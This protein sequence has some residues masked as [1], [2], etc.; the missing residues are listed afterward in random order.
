MLACKNLLISSLNLNVSNDLITMKK[1]LSLVLIFSVSMAMPQ[2]KD[3]ALQ[4]SNDY[5][6][7][8]NILIDD[9]FIAAEKEYRK[10]ISEKP[11]NTPAPYN[12]GNAYYNTGHFNEALLRHVEAANLATTKAEKT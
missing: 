6:Y 8:G 4:K 5:V 7:E 9:D 1:I 11:N 12:L 2:E 10:A 3:K